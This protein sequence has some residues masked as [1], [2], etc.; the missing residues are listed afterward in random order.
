MTT[1]VRLAA[2]ALVLIDERLLLV[3]AYPGPGSNLWCAPGGGCEAGESIP[4]TLAREVH[5]ETGLSIIVGDLAGAREFYNAGTGF[6][7]AELFFHAS[8]DG[9]LPDGWDDPA[10]VVHAR[11]LADRAMLPGLAHKPDNLAAMAFDRIPI[12]YHGMDRMVE[13][14]EL[15]E[16]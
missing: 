11:C 13:R 10:G 9:P 4:E 2:R 16:I 1:T 6:H 5:E 12:A 14:S 8:A 7:Q 3:N 15:G